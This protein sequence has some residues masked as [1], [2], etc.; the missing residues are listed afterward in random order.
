MG[1]ELPADLALCQTFSGVL[2]GEY[3]LVQEVMNAATDNNFPNFAR[4]IERKV[5]GGR[6][7][8]MSFDLDSIL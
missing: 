6:S 5:I 8:E 3:D 1:K 2:A 4:E 7:S